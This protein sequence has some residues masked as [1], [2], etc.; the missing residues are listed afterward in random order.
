MTLK[1]PQPDGAATEQTVRPAE[2]QSRIDP[3]DV[4]PGIV[5][6]RCW[7]VHVPG[8][9]ER[10]PTCQAPRPAGGWAAMPYPLNDRYTFTRLLGRGGQGAVYLAVDRSAELDAEGRAPSRA[11]KVVQTID[12]AAVTRA[13]EEFEHEVA[14]AALLGRSPAYVRVFGYDTGSRPY[15]VM[16]PVEW[17]TLKKVLRAGT[18]SSVQAA[19]LGIALLEALEIMHFFRMVHRDLK[20]SNMFVDEIDGSWR[21]KVA[22]LGIWVRDH[23]AEAP[24]ALVTDHQMIHGTP[25]YMS[26]EQMAGNRIGTRSDQHAVASILWQCVTGAVPFPVHGR[27]PVDQVR[28]RRGAVLQVPGSPKGMHPGLYATLARALAPEPADRYG[29]T[30]AMI[31]ALQA[32][33]AQ[34]SKGQGWIDEAL[35]EVAGLEARVE[36][37]RGA[38]L[39]PE[40]ATRLASIERG[41]RMLVEYLQ[42]PGAAHR[43]ARKLLRTVRADL[44]KVTEA[45]DDPY[46]QGAA[47]DRTVRDDAPEIPPTV[48]LAPTMPVE[49]PADV[50]PETAPVTPPPP[51]ADPITRYR[52]DGLV[53]AGST[54]RIYE[55]EQLAL[56]RRV[57]VRVMHAAGIADLGVGDSARFFREMNTAAARIEHPHVVRVYDLDT[58]ADEVPFVAQ[59]LLDGPSLQAR[60]KTERLIDPGELIRLMAPVASGLAAAHAA[61]VMHLNLKPSRIILRPLPG[62]PPAPVLFGFGFDQDTVDTLLS[63]SGLYGTPA[64]MAPEQAEGRRGPASDVYGLGTIIFRCLVGLLPFFGATVGQVLE[65]KRS[66]DAPLLPRA[67]AN[68]EPIGEGLRA[69]V[70]SMLHRDPAQ[71]PSAEAVARALSGELSI[72]G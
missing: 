28:R 46:A 32:V 7:Q 59:T 21:V 33:V 64:Y 40:M 63:S 23:D 25:P 37:L 8:D 34:G 38:Q 45:A 69:L 31:T 52:L 51:A 70:G 54:S 47:A 19:R 66:A 44:V 6:T 26:P 72:V 48:E 22:D 2:P 53:G 55:A 12:E 11:I 10:C 68:G 5:C 3:A 41:L 17:P 4:Q 29:R 15:L 58:G 67:N 14:A 65:Q 13:A 56:G 24:E 57:A 27:S 43:A 16:E 71:R 36:G 30:R 35:Q 60:L 20:P 49:P 50:L 61:R 18:L 9:P 1:L 39:A 42:A 62:L